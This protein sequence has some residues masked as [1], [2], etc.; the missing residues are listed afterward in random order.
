MLPPPGEW[1]SLHADAAAEGAP[2]GGGVLL[3]LRGCGEGVATGCGRHAERS[4]TDARPTS[5]R[6]GAELPK[7]T[8]E[9]GKSLFSAALQRQ[10]DLEK[11]EEED[12][13]KKFLADVKK[14]TLA[15]LRQAD[16]DGVCSRGISSTTTVSDVLVYLDNGLKNHGRVTDRDII[17]AAV[18]TH[19][20]DD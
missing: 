12:F 20:A 11:K 1:C 8:G 17:L 10:R 13:R 3:S 19:D 5:R 2:A 14:K 6:R 9:A 7:E 4:W 18:Q 15:R 16:A